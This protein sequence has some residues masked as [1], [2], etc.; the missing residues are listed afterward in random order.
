MK[1]Q[2]PMEQDSLSLSGVSQIQFTE[3]KDI[4]QASN[5]RQVTIAHEIFRRLIVS[6]RPICLGN[7]SVIPLARTLLKLLKGALQR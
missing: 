1:L 4:V 6:Q 7:I 5:L 2:P 3:G